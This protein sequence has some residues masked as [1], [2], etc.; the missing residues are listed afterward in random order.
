M[1]KDVLDVKKDLSREKKEVKKKNRAVIG[2][3]IATGVLALSTIGLG[4]GVAISQSQA[5]SYRGDLESVYQKSMYELVDSV[6]STET[7]LAKV[8]SSDGSA[9]QKKMLLEV[10]KNTNEAQGYISSLPLSQSDIQETV[11][12][13]NQIS[14][15]TSTLAEKLS[16]GG[17]LTESEMDTLADIHQNILQMKQELNT[18]S[19]KME[20]G[21]N[22][23]D[24]SLDFD[25]DMNMLTQ[26]LEK[27]HDVDVDYPTMIYDGPFS[28]S[29]VS[30]QIKGLSGAN[31][32]QDEALERIN[33]SFKNLSSVEFEN[34]TSGRFETFNFRATNS[35]D[36]N[37][38]IQVTKIGGHILTVSGAGN[39]DREV[40]VNYD[41]AKKIALDFAK[42]NGIEEGEVVWTDTIYDQT[43][44]NIAPVENGVVIYPDLVKVKVDLTSGTVV[45]YDA[46]TYFTNHTDR[47]I[48]SALVSKDS[49]AKS[50]PSDFET[51]LSRLALVPLEYN[52]DVLC[53][54]FECERGDEVYYFYFNAK[55]GEEENILK[56]I[57]TDDGSK[58]M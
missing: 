8:L 19:R 56:V 47:S 40:E 5:M 22:L 49:V 57:K 32:N 29:V 24:E 7:K 54:E 11:K 58:L 16:A 14:G 21:Y 39:S 1:K 44:F 9:Y 20:N 36:E 3:S 51:T 34:Q 30:A 17:T 31:I 18:L 27:M 55:T 28:D 42:S 43:Y 25:G 50:V 38:Y 15:Y 48:G 35:D 6:N 46:T 33:S 45:G 13:V 52:R 26:E 23:M 37:L 4:V 2:L 12:M 41:Q 10:S 53:W